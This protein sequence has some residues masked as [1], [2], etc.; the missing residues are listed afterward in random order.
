MGTSV[1]HAAHMSASGMEALNTNVEMGN[2][3]QSLYEARELAMERMQEEALTLQAEGIVGSTFA[4]GATAGRA[5]SSSSSPWGRPWS[6][7][8]ES[9]RLRS[10]RC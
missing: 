7:P 4:S 5:T 8:L 3:T 6:P 1:Y 9:R 10:P 2:F